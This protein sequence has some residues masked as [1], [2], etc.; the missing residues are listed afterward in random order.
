M[1]A[2]LCRALLLSGF[3][4]A[5]YLGSRPARMVAKANGLRNAT[6]LKEAVKGGDADRQE[7]GAF[8]GRQQWVMSI[9]LL[10]LVSILAA[11]Q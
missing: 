1:D 10:F 5:E 4:D 11:F 6:P 8:L 9:H 7:F 2:P 3:D